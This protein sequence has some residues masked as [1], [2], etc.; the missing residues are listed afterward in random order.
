MRQ[1][2]EVKVTAAGGGTETSSLLDGRE[3]IMGG[4]KQK[5]CRARQQ[6]L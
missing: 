3:R 1:S 4:G 5:G 6:N 2:E